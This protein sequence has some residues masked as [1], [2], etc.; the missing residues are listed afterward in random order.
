MSLCDPLRSRKGA[1]E[2]RGVYRRV[3]VLL[4]TPASSVFPHLATHSTRRSRGSWRQSVRLGDGFGE[5]VVYSTDLTILPCSLV[6]TLDRLDEL[7]ADPHTAPL[8]AQF[9]SP[10]ELRKRI[11]RDFFRHGFD[12]SGDDG[13]SCIDGAL[14]RRGEEGKRTGPS[15]VCAGVCAAA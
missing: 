1:E 5:P 13:G 15:G 3:L 12:G 4:P 14:R 7:F 10:E 6:Q 8:V 11:L 9:D 2:Q